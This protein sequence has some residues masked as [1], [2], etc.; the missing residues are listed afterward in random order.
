MRNTHQICLA[1]QTSLGF[2]VFF[3]V[4]SSAKMMSRYVH[5][6]CSK[7]GTSIFNSLAKAT[8]S[9]KKRCGLQQ[10]IT[11]GAY[12]RCCWPSVQCFNRNRFAV[13]SYSCN[14]EVLMK[15]IFSDSNAADVFTN[16]LEA[17]MSLFRL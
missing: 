17:Q 8:E 4:I 15:N 14:R 3:K 7:D 16:V 5:H 2:T 11:E 1:A 13:K 10:R 12:L 9:R 6:T